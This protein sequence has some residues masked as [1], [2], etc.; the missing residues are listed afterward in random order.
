MNVITLF[1]LAPAEAKYE[2]N[3]T[4]IPPVFC[5]SAQGE[6][7]CLLVGCAVPDLPSDPVCRST[8]S[9]YRLKDQSRIPEGTFYFIIIRLWLGSVSIFLFIFLKLFC[10][11][12]L[13]LEDVLLFVVGDLHH[14]SADRLQWNDL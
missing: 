1:H 9:V 13:K 10:V 5:R 6:I 11:S 7:C 12:A 14:V 4:S 8:V 2:R 3:F